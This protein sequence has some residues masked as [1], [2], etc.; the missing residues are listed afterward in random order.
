[1]KEISRIPT[2]LTIDTTNLNIYNY[3]CINYISNVT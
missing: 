2:G 3:D 1:M